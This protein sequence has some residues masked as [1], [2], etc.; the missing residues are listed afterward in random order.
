MYSFRHSNCSI[1]IAPCAKDFSCKKLM[2][3]MLPSLPPLTVERLGGL[4]DGVAMHNGQMVCVPKTCAH[5]RILASPHK[6]AGGVIHA[7]LQ[8]ILSAGPD[9]RPAPCPHHDSCGGC[10]LQHLM[11]DAYQR[12]KHTVFAN[13]LARA[14]LTLQQ[15]AMIH[16]LPIASR[17]R[18]DFRLTLV[19]GA[20]QLAMH[21][22][23]SH[24]LT[25]VQ[26]CSILCP[27][28][29]TVL[30]QICAAIGTLP[31]DM[32]LHALAL[33][34]LDSGL[35]MVFEGKAPSASH[36]KALIH[37][38]HHVGAARISYAA[39]GKPPSV[40]ARHK[41]ATLTL[42]TA[43]LEPPPAGFLQAS[44]QAQSLMTEA[45]M[46]AADGISRAIDL[47]C[48]IGTFA[49]PLAS[50]GIACLAYESDAPA[51]AALQQG[52]AQAGLHQLDA[53][54]RNLFTAPVSTET[55]NTVE[56][57]VINPPRAGASAQCAQLAH[58]QARRIVMISCNP[59]TF[60]R[61]A[62]ILLDGG[63]HLAHIQAADQFVYS[64]HLEIIARFER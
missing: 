24:A 62:K 36:T 31:A 58:S 9:R 30:P 47:F 12:F 53:Q 28:L 37:L 51:I 42:G 2:P 45:V 11:P 17:R 63:W 4:G 13:T 48:G 6:E 14:G 18:A 54:R 60:S 27:P 20:W 49:L 29:Q 41:P 34:H 39:P 8:E 35:D 23:Q 43:T 19:E 52:A 44:Q 5:D 15:P 26:Q 50:A 10:A 64:A 59:A 3:K 61:D 7:R 57:V 22:P 33:T 32:P 46:Q 38:S 21:Q 1:F 55:L 25:P 56:L 40:L 16:F